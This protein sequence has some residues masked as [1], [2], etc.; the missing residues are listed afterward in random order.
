[1]TRRLTALF[2][3]PCALLVFAILA[4]LLLGGC[5]ARDPYIESNPK[6]ISNYL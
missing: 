3:V 4:G 6:H 2:W 1:M 5:A